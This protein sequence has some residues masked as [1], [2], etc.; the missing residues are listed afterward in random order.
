MKNSIIALGVLLLCPLTALSQDSALTEH[1]VVETPQ[2][3]CRLRLTEDADRLGEGR[4][5]MVEPGCGLPPIKRYVI[6][7]TQKIRFLNGQGEA[8]LTLVYR[9]EA[10]YIGQLET[11][12]FVRLHRPEPATDHSADATLSPRTARPERPSRLLSE[13]PSIYNR[14]S[15]S[16]DCIRYADTR[17][18]A[19][20]ADTGL[21]ASAAFHPPV[22]TLE[23]LNLHFMA[24]G[25]SSL[26]GHVEAGKCLRVQGCID[27]SLDDEIWCEVE[28][29]DD[30]SWMLK[31][32]DDFVYAKTGCN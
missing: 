3:T 26:V 10:S 32:G 23:S 18:C 28:D 31:Q 1:W 24:G 4:I 5:E 29:G 25:E 13:R 19:D 22:F 12:E 11:N 14:P 17:L 7:E 27:R 9:A 2:G 8:V 21:P 15:G 20:E 16:D 6:P 30:W